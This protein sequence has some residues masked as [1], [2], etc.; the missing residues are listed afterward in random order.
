[1]WQV[2]RVIELSFGKLLGGKCISLWSGGGKQS[3]YKLT[4]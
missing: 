2:V 4:Y 3:K 1:M